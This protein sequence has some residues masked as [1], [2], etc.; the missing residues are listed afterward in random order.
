MNNV[1][2]KEIKKIAFVFAIVL[3]ILLLLFFNKQPEIAITF[4]IGMFFGIL[5]LKA[6]FSY[7]NSLLDYEKSNKN[8]ILLLS[9]IASLFLA[10]GVIGFVLYKSVIIGLSMIFGLVAVPVILMVYTLWKG[11]SLFR[12]N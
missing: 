5:R 8:T 1:M 4:L 2:F 7:I 3:A 6:L 11:I 12:K 9:Y 10:I